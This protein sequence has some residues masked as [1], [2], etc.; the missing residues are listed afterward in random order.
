MESVNILC[1]VQFQFTVSRV[2]L[3]HNFQYI[4]VVLMRILTSGGAFVDGPYKKVTGVGEF[5]L[6][7]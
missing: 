2:Q 6:K 5:F 7:W 4:F 3:L 1:R